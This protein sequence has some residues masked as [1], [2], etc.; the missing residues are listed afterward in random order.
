MVATTQQGDSAVI[1]L[2]L[3]GLLLGVLLGY[4]HAIPLQLVQY[5]EPAGQWL[6]I[7][8]LFFVGID[9]GSNKSVLGRIKNAGWRLLFVPFS[10]II[11]SLLAGLL[12]SM[13]IDLSP[14]EALA[15]ASGMGYYTLSSVLIS[16]Q[17]SSQL[18]AIAFMSNIIRE[19][20]TI[21]SAPWLGRWNKLAPVAAGGATAMDTTLPVITLYTSKTTAIIAVISGVVITLLVPFLVT[22]FTRLA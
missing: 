16:Q 4:F 12:L 20:L 1:A 10:I 5:I 22:L 17:L 14:A 7:A 2:I 21:L 6:L 13:F 11:G 3:L 19:V 18:G 8:L 15:I 9:V